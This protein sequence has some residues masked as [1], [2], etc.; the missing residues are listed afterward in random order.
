M[1]ESNKIPNYT[2]Q[3]TLIHNHVPIV[4]P[5]SSTQSD[6]P[7]QPLFVTHSVPP[8]IEGHC[9]K[10]NYPGLDL[11]PLFNRTIKFNNRDCLN[12]N[13]QFIDFKLNETYQCQMFYKTYTIKY[14]VIEDPFSQS[15][16][17]F[18]SNQSYQHTLIITDQVNQWKNKLLTADHPYVV[19]ILKKYHIT[20]QSEQI[21]NKNRILIVH[22]RDLSYHFKYI[23]WKRIIIDNLNYIFT[24]TKRS[25]NFTAEILFNLKHQGGYIFIDDLIKYRKYSYELLYKLVF[26]TETLA[27]NLNVH[28]FFLMNLIRRIRYNDRVIR[29]LKKNVEF[30]QFTPY[31]NKLYHLLSTEQD[32]LEYCA[33]SKTFIPY[34]HILS[35]ESTNEPEKC[36]ICLDNIQTKTIT[37][38]G[39]LACF[40]CLYTYALHEK[41]RQTCPICK[42]NL[43][44]QS[45]QV[46]VEDP[47]DCEKMLYGAKLYYLIDLIKH[48]KY[49]V[50]MS[51]RSILI[52]IQNTTL[53]DHVR[54]KLYQ[55]HLLHTINTESDVRIINNINETI[56]KHYDILL[57]MEF[58]ISIVPFNCKHKYYLSSKTKEF[59]ATIL[60]NDPKIKI[61]LPLIS[62]TLEETIFQKLIK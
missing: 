50:Q 29:N 25:Q 58:D 15:K 9:P 44:Y 31:E 41:K 51:D 57:M 22:Y 48:I 20:T 2:Y 26:Q 13:G 47:S 16:Y 36:F 55:H 42:S 35:D 10:L 21:Q 38:C 11:S 60:K 3:T 4:D 45:F 56:N 6:Y 54:S 1:I 61:K 52:Y 53:L 33:H 19:Q 24:L 23:K 62:N 12:F 46:E 40:S 39:H 17:D 32:K 7:T 28:K 49:D 5:T 43:I 18:I 37:N 34:Q 59:M 8:D 14:G 30:L 27:D